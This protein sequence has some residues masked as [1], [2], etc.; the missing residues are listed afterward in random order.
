M[1]DSADAEPHR[2]RWRTRLPVDLVPVL[3]SGQ[4]AVTTEGVDH[5][6]VGRDRCQTAE[7]LAD[8]GD[9]HEQLRR[10]GADGAGDQSRCS[11]DQEGVTRRRRRRSPCSASTSALLRQG[12]DHRQVQHQ[13]SDRRDVDRPNDRL[14]CLGARALGLL[15]DVSR[16]VE[17]GDRVLGEQQAE[18]EQVHG[19]EHATGPSGHSGRGRVERTADASLVGRSDEEHTGDDDDTDD[20]PPHADVAEDLDQVDAERVQQTMYDEHDEVDRED[21]SSS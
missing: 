21:R 16:R 12:S 10:A 1:A 3:R 7:E 5:A 20:M 9:E 11:V 4:G 15:T 18:R 2:V 14:R 8:E 19:D 13:R 17:A 6:A